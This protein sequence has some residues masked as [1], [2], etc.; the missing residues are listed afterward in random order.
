MGHIGEIPPQESHFIIKKGTSNVYW[1]RWIIGIVIMY[2]GSAVFAYLV[3]HDTSLYRGKDNGLI[4]L[5]F[6]RILSSSIFFML[7]KKRILHLPGIG[8]FTGFLMYLLYILFGGDLVYK[9]NL[10]DQLMVSTLIVICGSL[11]VRFFRR[12]T[13][14]HNT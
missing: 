8:I 12:F 11:Y 1:V 9:S 13:L 4:F 10:V 5:A 7:I 3:D 14:V 6:T 2:A